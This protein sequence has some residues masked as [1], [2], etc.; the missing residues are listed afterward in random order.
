LI[1]SCFYAFDKYLCN[2]M[3]YVILV[4]VLFFLFRFI[5]RFVLPIR[6]ATK[7]MRD[8]VRNMQQNN[9]QNTPPKPNTDK[10][11]TAGEYIDFEEI[12]DENK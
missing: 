6:N 3:G 8:N 10:T 4:F 11:S 1:F 9:P 7:T 5:I 2:T 12:K